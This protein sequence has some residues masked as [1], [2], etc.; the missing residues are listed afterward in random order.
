VPI[1]PKSTARQLSN[2]DFD[3]FTHILAMDEYT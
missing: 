1:D 2:P 3:N